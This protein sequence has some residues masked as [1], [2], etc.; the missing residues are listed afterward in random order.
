MRFLLMILLAAGLAFGPASTASAGTQ[1]KPPDPKQDKQD[2]KA[3]K[4]DEKPGQE[5]PAPVK[6]VN[7]EISQMMRDMQFALEG[8]SSRNFLQLIDSEKFDDFPRFQDRIERLMQDDTIRAY[9]RNANTSP[10]TAAGKAQTIVDAE[11]EIGRKNSTTQPQ[12]RRQQLVIDFENT[13][14]G[15]RITNITPRSYFDPL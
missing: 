13:R 2:D 15:W 8:G 7:R 4:K 9:F 1:A 10:N 14:R 3:K 12:R 5:A 11:M 6:D